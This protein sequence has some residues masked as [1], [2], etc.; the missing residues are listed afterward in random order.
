MSADE[1][2]PVPQWSPDGSQ[3]ALVHANNN[4]IALGQP[5]TATLV[6][7]GA[8]GGEERE[9]VHFELALLDEENPRR[10]TIAWNPAG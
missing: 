10:L 8:D 3:I 9:L 4:V 7:V 6:V 2:S 5:T 1:W